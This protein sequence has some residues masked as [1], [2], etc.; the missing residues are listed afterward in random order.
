MF[1]LSEQWT[2]RGQPLAEDGAK[3]DQGPGVGS[4]G[5]VWCHRTER[6]YPCVKLIGERGG[7]I[8]VWGTCIPLT[9]MCLCGQGHVSTDTCLLYESAECYKCV[10]VC[11]MRWD[12]CTRNSKKWSQH[13]HFLWVP[14][15][16]GTAC[17]HW[18]SGEPISSHITIGGVSSLPVTV[19]SLYWPA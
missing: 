7:G 6:Q 13:S 5:W 15:P 10:C 16:L 2:R 3:A 11:V 19:I 17:W 12:L 18:D 8:W 1:S 9:P 4:H 14:L